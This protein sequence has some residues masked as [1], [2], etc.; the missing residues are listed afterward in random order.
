M[1]KIEADKPK[2]SVSAT[3]RAGTAAELPVD[4]AF[5]ARRADAAKIN[6][7]TIRKIHITTRKLTNH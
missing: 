7:Y 4:F 6:R 2:D 5:N 3:T 1:M